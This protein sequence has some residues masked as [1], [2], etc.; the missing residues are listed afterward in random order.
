[1][2]LSAESSACSTEASL[3]RTAE[4]GQMTVSMWEQQG[5]I[6]GFLS[7]VLYFWKLGGEDSCDAPALV[8]ADGNSPEVILQEISKGFG[9]RG[10][11]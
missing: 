4:S 8:G 2:L 11:F 10:C 5:G 3:L 6:W 7:F 9:G 1:M